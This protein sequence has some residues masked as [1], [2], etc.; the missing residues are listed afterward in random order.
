MLFRSMFHQYAFG[1]VINTFDLW[2]EIT[3]SGQGVIA[4]LSERAVLPP[5][6]MQSNSRRRFKKRSRSEFVETP[7]EEPSFE[8]QPSKPITNVATVCTF[9]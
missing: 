1:L 9:R 7:A 8:V 4:Y 2:R 6:M 3:T 5:I